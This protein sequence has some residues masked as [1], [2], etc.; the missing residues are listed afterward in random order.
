M[1]RIGSHLCGG[2]G[3]GGDVECS[4]VAIEHKFNKYNNVHQNVDEMVHDRA[5]QRTIHAGK[6]HGA[7]T[8]EVRRGTHTF[9]KMVCGQEED[10]W[11]NFWIHC[12]KKEVSASRLLQR[13]GMLVAHI[14]TEK[15]QAARGVHTVE[16]LGSGSP[17]GAIET[18]GRG[19]LD[20]RGDSKQIVA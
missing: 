20:L 5:V 8:T 7:T 19:S 16:E 4:P 13:I 9:R 17:D 2:P 18:E 10:V 12:P 14:K 11:I 1:D 3:G 15:K 6:K